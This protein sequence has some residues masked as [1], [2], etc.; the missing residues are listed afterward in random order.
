MTCALSY[1]ICEVLDGQVDS[2]LGGRVQGFLQES[3]NES[4]LQ[5]LDSVH[6]I[7]L[8]NRKKLSYYLP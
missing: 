4:K 5:Y 1:Q 7:L 3:T 6:D 8:T 2:L